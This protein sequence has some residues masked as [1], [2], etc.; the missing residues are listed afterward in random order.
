M[1]PDVTD[2]LVPLPLA[3]AAPAGVT[4]LPSIVYL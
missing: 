4:P 3:V 1:E 2:G